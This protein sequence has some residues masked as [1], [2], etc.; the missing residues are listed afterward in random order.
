[1]TPIDV[2]AVF[3]DLDGTLLDTIPDLAAAVNATLAD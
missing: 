2:R 1:M 3:F